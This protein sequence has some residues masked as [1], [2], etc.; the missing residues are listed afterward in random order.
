LEVFNLALLAKQGWRLLSNPESLV[1]RIMKAKYHPRVDFMDA[2]LGSRPSFVRLSILKA[3]SILQNGIGWRVGNG[4]DIK[5][6]KDVWL[7]PP[8]SRLLLTNNTNWHPESRVS[9]LIDHNSGWWNLD[10]I[11][12]LFDPGEAADI[13]S[14]VISPL[15]KKD[16]IIWRGSPSGVFTVRSAY[17]MK[18]RRRAQEKGESSSVDGNEQLWKFIWSLPTTPVLRNFCWKLCHDLLPTK[19][20]L[21][22]QKVVANPICPICNGEPETI[23]QCLWSCPMAVGIWQEG[24][25]KLQKM[26]CGDTDGRGLLLFFQ[27]KL[28]SEE[29][30]EALSILRMIWL[31]RNTFIFLRAN[32]LLH[33]K[34]WLLCT[35]R[36]KVSPKL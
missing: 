16:K 17:H 18:M 21:F 36:W 1:A 15:L 14:V 3:N 31:T 10:L 5:I 23:F 29:L 7:N 6:W 11:H 25:R 33:P 2:K 35:N 8:K 30:I 12:R 4:E 34:L 28:E 32:L 19:F 27:D 22:S 13:G 26:A 20:N 24:S 9:S